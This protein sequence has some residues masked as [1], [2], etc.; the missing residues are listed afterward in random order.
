MG[1]SADPTAPDGLEQ[2]IEGLDEELRELMQKMVAVGEY[3]LVL[4]INDAGRFVI[5]SPQRTSALLAHI[6]S[7]IPNMLDSAAEALN[8]MAKAGRRH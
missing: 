3:S 1:V 7:E 2:V 8:D 5:L 6:I 4:R